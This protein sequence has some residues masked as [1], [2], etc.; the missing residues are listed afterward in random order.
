M[1][2]STSPTTRGPEGAVSQQESHATLVRPSHGV[3]LSVAPCDSRMCPLM[4]QV[5]GWEGALRAG[6]RAGARGG[7]EP[8]AGRGRM[9]W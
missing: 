8:P 4:E 5:V 7:G 6:V 9:A 2:P 3:A 1:R